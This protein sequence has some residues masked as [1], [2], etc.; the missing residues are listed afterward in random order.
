MP[1]RAPR[2]LAKFGGGQMAELI[3]IEF[4][5]LREGEVQAGDTIER[6]N[7]DENGVSVADIIR[8][9]AFEK[10]DLETLRR[11]VQL[12]TLPESW[13]VYFLSRLQRYDG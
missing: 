2:D 12:K 11:V 10:D 13:R 1:P 3:A 4:A 6:L 9:Y 7:R 5:V 8:L